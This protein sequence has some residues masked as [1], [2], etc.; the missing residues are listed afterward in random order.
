MSDDRAYFACVAVAVRI[1][2]M[3]GPWPGMQR[4]LI[5]GRITFFLLDLLKQY[6]TE[7]GEDDGAFPATDAH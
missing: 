7:G 1:T 6:G 3:L 5:A 4:P 2:D